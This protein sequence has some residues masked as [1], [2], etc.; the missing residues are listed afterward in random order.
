MDKVRTGPNYIEFYDAG[1]EKSRRLVPGPGGTIRILNEN[2]EVERNFGDVHTLKTKTVKRNVNGR[3]EFASVGSNR[4][5]KVSVTGATTNQTLVASL[6]VVANFIQGKATLKTTNVITAGTV[7]LNVM[8][9]TKVLATDKT[10]TPTGTVQL[11]VTAS[12]ITATNPIVKVTNKNIAGGTIKTLTVYN[13]CNDL[14]TEYV[15]PLV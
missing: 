1:A 9:G 7:V 12:N 3:V 6:N 15:F 10:T 14:L 13:Q 11:L 5:T 2:G 8:D 4:G